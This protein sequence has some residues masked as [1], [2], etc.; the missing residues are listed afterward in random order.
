MSH[1]SR[2]NVGRAWSLRR[3]GAKI[4]RFAAVPS[5]ACRRSVS[6]TPERQAVAC[7]RLLVKRQPRDS[8]EKP[9][10]SD[11][12]RPVL[13]AFASVFAACTA[14]IAHAGIFRAYLSLSGNDA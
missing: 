4:R 8:L 1:A 7:H 12:L 13:I 9:M 11:A 3:L 5:T 6:S 14:S 2:N 10:H